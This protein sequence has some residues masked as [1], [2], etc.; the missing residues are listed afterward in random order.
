MPKKKKKKPRRL[1]KFKGPD[2]C[3][4][5]AH[6]SGPLNSFPEEAQTSDL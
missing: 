5:E 1:G 6:L 4:E 3:A 2:K